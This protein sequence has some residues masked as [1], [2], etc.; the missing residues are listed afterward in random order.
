MSGP[1]VM[2]ESCGGFFAGG[3][4]RECYG[5]GIPICGVCEDGYDLCIDCNTREDGE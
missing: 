1:L 3:D 5:C 2:C 4:I